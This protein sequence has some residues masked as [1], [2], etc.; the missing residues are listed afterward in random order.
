MKPPEIIRKKNPRSE[1][2]QG[3]LSEIE[4]R[5]MAG[6]DRETE[7][8]STVKSPAKSKKQSGRRERGKRML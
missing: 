2:F 6:I 8:S 7:E 4:Q 1:R 3:K 5:K